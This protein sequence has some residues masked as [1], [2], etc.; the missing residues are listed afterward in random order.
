MLGVGP[1]G[2]IMRRAAFEAVGGF[3]GRQFVGDGE[4]WLKLAQRWPV[5]SLPPALVWW[6]RHEGQQMSLEQARP[7]VLN[8]RY[9][10]ECETLEETALLDAT[11]KRQ[12]WARLRH[13]HGRMLLSLAL[14]N[15]QVGMAWK[16]FR[17]SGLGGRDLLRGLRRYG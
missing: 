17:T 16:L 2:A 9:R 11:E 14:K 5:V 12:A 8:V 4:L 1:T 10:L 13:R 6:R 15:F 3:S 7:E